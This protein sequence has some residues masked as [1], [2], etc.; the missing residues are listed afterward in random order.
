[1]RLSLLTCYYLVKKMALTILPSNMG[2]GVAKE[3]LLFF[4]WSLVTLFY[5]SL[6]CPF[7]TLSVCASVLPFNTCLGPIDLSFCMGFSEVS[8]KCSVSTTTQ[9]SASCFAQLVTNRSTCD[10][11]R[12]ITNMRQ[13][14]VLHVFV[15]RQWDLPIPNVVS[16]PC[17]GSR[18]QGTAT[19]KE[20]F[21][22]C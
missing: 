5:F 21:L 17:G 3:L 13:N 16:V 15:I 2:V 1:M 7:Y 19:F 11:G 9:M 12:E 20:L 22:S 8:S 4:L 14:R 10:I 6:V 18:Q